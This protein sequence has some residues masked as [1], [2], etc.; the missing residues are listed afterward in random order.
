MAFELFCI[1]SI[2]AALSFVYIFCVCVREVV[3]F[4]KSKDEE[5]DI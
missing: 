5:G 3:H 2:P 1:L 4:K